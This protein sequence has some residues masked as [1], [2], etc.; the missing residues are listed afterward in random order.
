MCVA[1]RQ[2]QTGAFGWDVTTGLER[3]PGPADPVGEHH[4]KESN[5]A[6]T[7]LETVPY[8]VPVARFVNR[9]ECLA[10][11]APTRRQGAR[12]TRGRAAS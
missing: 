7:V 5:L 1:T 2:H 12:P 6:G 9:R 8:P 4:V 11:S 3:P 10:L